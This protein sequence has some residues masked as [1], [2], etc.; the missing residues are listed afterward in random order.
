M[1]RW[2]ALELLLPVDP[3]GAPHGW[4]DMLA[5]ALADLAPTAVQE[6]DDCWRVFFSSASDRDRALHALNAGAPWLAA[7]SPIDVDDEDWARR[8]QETLQAVQVGRI[9]IAPPWAAGGG[10]DP[11]AF[12]ILILPSMGFGTGHHASTRL[13]TALLQELDLR[14]RSVR[15]VGTGSGVLA[16]AALRLGARAVEGL[17]DD[18]D[19]ISA[20]EENL[21]LNQVSGGISLRRTDFRDLESLSADVVTA[22]LTGALLA[23]SAVLLA[24]AVRAGGSLIVSGVTLD[25]EPIVAAAFEQHL[26]PASRMIE[27]GWVGLRFEKKP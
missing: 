13:C 6:Q 25:E 5:A 17:D 9:V 2:P 27:E 18:P 10:T 21:E 8:S 20:A 26:R 11:S 23:R 15:D 4:Q 12:E 3:G 24:G 22:N 7:V 19:A 1:K 14:G 16:L